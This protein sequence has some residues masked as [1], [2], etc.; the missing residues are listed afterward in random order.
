M[1]LRAVC[2]M[3]GAEHFISEA[4]MA[5]IQSAA[6]FCGSATGTNPAFA[7]A[8]QALGE[9][10]AASGIKLVYGGGGIGLMGVVARAVQG[11]GGDLV[12]VMPDFLMRREVAHIGTGELI[13]TDS[14]HSRK[15][16]MFELA[17]AFVILPGG[18]GT[19]DEFFEILTWRQLRL[20]DKPILIC[21]IAGYAAPWVAIVDTAIANGFAQPGARDLFEVLDGVAALLTRLAMLPRPVS[22]PGSLL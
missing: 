7:A 14:M 19:L 4:F 17:D 2:G 8:A 5:H 18:L 9:A 22:Q 21:D 15:R 1:M 16:R 12:G 6:V 10:M 20:H 13:V 11:A 3:R